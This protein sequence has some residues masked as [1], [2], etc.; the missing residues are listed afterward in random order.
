MF[1]PDFSD[2]KAALKEKFKARD[3]ENPFEEIVSVYNGFAMEIAEKMISEY[4]RQLWEEL[5]RQGVVK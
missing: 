5:K 2:L 4:H 3:P 1:E